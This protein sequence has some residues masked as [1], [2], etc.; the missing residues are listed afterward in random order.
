MFF[1]L[2]FLS[3]PLFSQSY[4]YKDFRDA[5][6][7]YKLNAVLD[8]KSDNLP[9]DFFDTHWKDYNKRRENN[10]AFGVASITATQNMQYFSFGFFRQKT[11]KIYLNSALIEV[12]HN[13]ENDFANILLYHQLYKDIGTAPLKGDVND[14]DSFGVFVEK[15]FHPLLHHYFDV[16]LKLHYAT[17]FNYIK[18]KGDSTSDAFHGTLDY[19]YKNENRISHA[20]NQ[21]SNSYGYGYSVDLSYIYNRDKFYFYFGIYNIGSYIFWR[22]VSLMHYYFDSNTICVGADGYKHYKPF[23]VGHYSYN[24]NFTQQIPIHA[25]SSVNY[26]ITKNIAVGDNISL[27]EKMHY[28]ELYANVKIASFRYKLGY[29]AENYNLIFA[30]YHKN[31]KFEISRGFNTSNKILQFKCEFLY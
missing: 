6:I 12:M 18:I 20:K 30:L 3:I 11:S 8:V 4:F 2:L 23:G 5:N 19:Y 9:L 24:I 27:Y 7:S 25:D 21:S 15:K 14:F 31:F 10:S 16:K 17:D 29:V 22:N 28:N 1:A 13:S 26:E